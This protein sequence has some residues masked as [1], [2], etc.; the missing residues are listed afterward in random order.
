MM[1]VVNRH[2]DQAIET[3]FETEDKQFAGA[4]RDHRGQRPGHQVGERFRQDHGAAGDELGDG[5]RAQA[6]LQLPAALVH[7]A[8]GEA[9]VTA[10]SPNPA[11]GR[12]SAARRRRP[13]A[14]RSP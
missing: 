6:A 10:T 9:G 5:G 2:R 1:N 11:G 13:A 7:D 12:E 4:G 8:E 3:E 14:S